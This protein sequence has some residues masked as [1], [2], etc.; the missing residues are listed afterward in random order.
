MKTSS[1]YRIQACETLQNHWGNAVLAAFVFLFITGLLGGFSTGINQVS[2][3]FTFNAVTSGISGV[4]G[5]GSIFLLIPLQYALYTAFLQVARREN[6]SAARAMFNDFKHN[7]TNFL[8]A[9]LL[10][11]IIIALLSIVT[12]GIAGVIF[13]Y[14]Y[15]MVP[16]LIKDY[17]NLSTTEIMRTSR[18]MMKGYKWNLF[19]LDLS[20]I[21]WAI[22]T[23]LTCG[24]GLLWFI[25]YQYTAVAH[26]YEDLKDERIVDTNT[27]E[28]IEE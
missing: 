2:T 15:R 9:G 22:L 27:E 11:N 17:P 18:K 5:L 12:L 28:A 7:Y 14:A 13:A 24:I 4:I 23:I 21:G 8:L 25:P 16:Y 1:N 6:A 3:Q 26:F 10:T 20:F 19:L